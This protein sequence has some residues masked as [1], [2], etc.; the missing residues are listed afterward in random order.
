MI[1]F[2]VLSIAACFASTSAFAL[3]QGEYLFNGFGTVGVT[4]LGGEDDGRSYGVQGQTI[5]SWRGDQVSKFGGQFQYGLSD[6]LS[7]TV[8]TTVMNRPG[9]R[10]GRFV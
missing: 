1:H 10:G 7:V 6:T 8:Q 2:R 3:D 4:H 9:F 5:D